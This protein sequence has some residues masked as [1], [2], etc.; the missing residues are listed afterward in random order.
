MISPFYY[1][2]YLLHFFYGQLLP[3]PKIYQIVSPQMPPN[4]CHYEPTIYK[5]ILPSPYF[6][7]LLL[8]LMLHEKILTIILQCLSHKNL[9]NWFLICEDYF[10]FSQLF[11][12]RNKHFS[13]RE[14]RILFTYLTTYLL[15]LFLCVVHYT[16][17]LV[18]TSMRLSFPLALTNWSLWNI[19]LELMYNPYH[20]SLQALL[21]SQ[22]SLLVFV[23]R[24]RHR[25][26]QHLPYLSLIHIA[27]ILS[28]LTT[29]PL[30]LLATLD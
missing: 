13:P 4:S 8:S 2:I 1:I 17:T 5:T 12:P 14:K 28:I 23:V 7:I 22:P 26:L 25:F 18:S 30:P 15:E 3:W 24:N 21:S 10:L 9:C 27:N 11:V 20:V 16:T 29:L 6:S 19:Y